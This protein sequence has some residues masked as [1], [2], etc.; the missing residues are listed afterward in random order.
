MNKIALR[1]KFTLLLAAMLC[2]GM[3]VFVGEYLLN[4]KKWVVFQGSPHVYSG[5]SMNCGVITD[6]TGEVLLDATDGRQYA[7]SALLRRATLH[8]LGDRKGN[9]LAPAV[10]EHS[11]QMVGFDLFNGIY[12]MNGKGGEATLTISASA[13]KA[14]LEALG[15]RKGT[16]GVY[17]YQT[18][19]I[20]CMVTS[21]NYDPDNVPDVNFNESEEYEGVYL[22]RFTQ[23]AYTPG[24]IFKL[25]TT[26]AALEEFAD[27]EEM[28]FHCDGAYQIGGDT[29][30]CEGVH[31]D[32][33]LKTAL[34]QSCNCAF[35]QLS[36]KFD[37]ATLQAYI[38]KF[39]LTEPVEFDGIRT[40]TGKFDVTDA[41]AVNVAWAAIGQY[42]D[43]MNPCR[44]MTF[45]G[46]IANGGKA[47]EPYLV[48]NVTS[49]GIRRYKA[50]TH[51][52]DKVLSSGA[53]SIL[54]KWM[55]NNVETVY[56]DGRFPDVGVCAKSGTAQVGGGKEPNATFAG[57][58]QDADYPLA[59]IVVVENGGAGAS[60]C[61]PIIS[62]VLE[63]CMKDMD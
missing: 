46:C 54:A 25:A 3:V 8:I 7:D 24:S 9:I 44:Y 19:E 39:Q 38:E 11:D 27:A 63:A 15:D 56:G 31:G 20:L 30:T 5:T 50:P 26:A 53:A 35:A 58:V 2:V 42:T 45:M 37:P 6:R 1:S 17:N 34:A 51:Q 49:G 40:A 55:R 32:I 4:A 33:S 47:A 13:Q 22:N 52:T 59:F 29:V 12:S 10:S 36:E 61:V 62:P 41:A 28:I 60:A 16:V 18:G 23:S 48:A 21:P 57:F 14:A 43:L